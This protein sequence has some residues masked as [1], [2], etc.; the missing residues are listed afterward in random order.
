ML[1]PDGTDGINISDSSNGRDASGELVLRFSAVITLNPE[2]FSFNNKHVLTIGP[3]GRYNVTDSYVQIQ[4]LFA[5][6]AED[7][8]PGDTV[9]NS[10]INTGN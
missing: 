10:N 5:K 9:C 2:V 6:R 1:V 7:C 4:S 8:L 3:A